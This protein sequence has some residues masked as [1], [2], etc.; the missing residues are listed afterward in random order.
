MDPN[1]KLV[2]AILKTHLQEI[3][4]QTDPPI[5]AT[6]PAT[7]YIQ[8]QNQWDTFIDNLWESVEPTVLKLTDGKMGNFSPSTLPSTLKQ[9]WSKFNQIDRYS[10][11]DKSYNL[12]DLQNMIADMIADIILEVLG[13]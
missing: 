5:S 6:I 2:I 11:L 1:N 13:K 8:G 4:L 7:I 10:I 12:V 9:V 3:A